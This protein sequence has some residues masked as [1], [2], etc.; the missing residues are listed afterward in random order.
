MTQRPSFLGRGWGFPITFRKATGD[1][2][3]RMVSEIEDIRESLTILFSTRPG[4]RVM[5]PDYGAALEDLLFE[6]INESL[7]NYVKDMV[8]KAILYYEPRVILE[9]MDLKDESLEGRLQLSL[10]ISVR[11]TNSRFNY[12]YDYYLREATIAPL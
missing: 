2:R 8:E 1:C 9:S 3:V 11:S 10:T 12:V 6:P 5:R 7:K 4:E